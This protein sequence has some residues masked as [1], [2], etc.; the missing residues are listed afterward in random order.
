MVKIIISPGDGVGKELAVEVQ[1]VIQC[2]GSGT[3]LKFKLQELDISEGHFRETELLLPLGFEKL[4]QDV[5]AV[6]LGPITIHSTLPEYSESI[7]LRKLCKQLKLNLYVR[8]IAPLQP[9]QQIQ[10]DHPIN[11]IVFEDPLSHQQILGSID[12]NSEILDVQTT[13]SIRSRLEA[14][15]TRMEA[16]LEKGEYHK[17]MLALP[18]K[19]L[20]KESPWIQ[21]L[22]LLSEKDYQV[23]ALPVDRFFF[24]FLRNPDQIGMVVTIPPYGSI[25]SRL[26]AVIEG[27]L[28]V[29]F[30]IYRQYDGL[31]LVHVLH[32]PSRRYQGRDAANPIGAILSVAEIMLKL[33]QTQLYKLIRKTVNDSVEAGW[34]TRDMGG[35]MGTMEIGD[36]VCSKLSAS[37]T[38]EMLVHH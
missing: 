18:D 34:T 32:P 11:I 8:K 38:P 27:G 24:Q 35:S 20:E 7:I 15:F 17:I 14:L 2:I 31:F 9:L 33:G 26:G 12:S 16:I 29:S 13:F 37:L 25:I 5:F 22:R 6:W 3:G 19:L 28:G 21:A 1:K 23:H 30:D 4:V 10:Y 36:Y